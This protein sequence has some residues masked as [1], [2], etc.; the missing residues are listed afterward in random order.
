MITGYFGLPGC[1]KTTFSV[2]IA[3]KYQKKG[4]R[5]FCLSDYPIDGC[6]LFDW[7]DLGTFDMSNSVIIIDEISLRADN[8]DYKKF[9][10][11]VKQFMILHRHYHCDVIWFT[12]QYDGLDKKIRELTTCLYYIR[13]LGLVSYAVRI[14]RFIH[15]DKESMQILVGYKIAGILQRLF[16][17]LNGS[18]KVCFRPFYYK[19]FDSYI[20]PRLHVREWTKCVIETVKKKK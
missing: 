3:K 7:D 13:S 11:A 20:A 9:S 10:Q 5:V 4:Y 2:K 19:Y 14:D 16:A 1:G 18:L 12:Q 6:Y 15:V 17:W 8:R